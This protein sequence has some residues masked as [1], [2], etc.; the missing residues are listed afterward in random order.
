MP[1]LPVEGPM[2]VFTPGTIS[3]ANSPS[4]SV[5][6][7]GPTLWL[8]EGKCV[9]PA[10]RCSPRRRSVRLRQH[11]WRTRPSG[12]RHVILNRWMGSSSSAASERPPSFGTTR[13]SE[14]RMQHFTIGGT[15]N[16]VFMSQNLSQRLRAWRA[17]FSAMAAFVHSDRALSRTI[18]RPFTIS[19]SR[20]RSKCRTA[21]GRK[22][23]AGRAGV[24]G[25]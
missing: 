16:Y 2:M 4:I 13:G 23:F 12:P 11:P 10:P 6:Y 22:D 20:A 25:K 17:A 5:A 9:P 14:L 15:G 24:G 8:P 19:E 3:P 18:Q 7:A 1:K 21:G